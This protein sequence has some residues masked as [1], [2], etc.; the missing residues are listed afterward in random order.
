[1]SM[2]LGALLAIII[3]MNVGRRP[4]FIY[5]QLFMTIFLFLFG[6][7]LHIQWNFTAFIFVNLFVFTFQASQATVSWLYIPEIT[8]D[9][10]TGIAVSF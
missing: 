2:L 4:I 9:T 1:M 6:L 8:I 10:G 5:G 3:I 7:S